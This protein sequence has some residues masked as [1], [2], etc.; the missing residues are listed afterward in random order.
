MWTI[1]RKTRW[2]H[3]DDGGVGIWEAMAFALAH[4]ALVGLLVL[5]VVLFHAALSAATPVA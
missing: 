5:A 1:M 4:L 3:R 2:S